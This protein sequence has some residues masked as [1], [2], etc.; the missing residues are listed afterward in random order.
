[1]QLGGW[2]AGLLS[3]PSHLLC[4]CPAFHAAPGK[5]GHRDSAFCLFPGILSSL[6]CT[7]YH[8]RDSDYDH[9]VTCPC[10]EW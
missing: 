8:E 9:E 6:Q 7:R 3:F 1:M 2:G 5:P 10:L 4:P